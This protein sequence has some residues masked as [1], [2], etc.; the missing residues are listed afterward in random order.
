MLLPRTYT[1]CKNPDTHINPCFSAIEGNLSDRVLQIAS[2]QQERDVP[3][4]S[5]ISSGIR[6]S[7][8]QF[9]PAG[10]FSCQLPSCMVFLWD[11]TWE[12]C[13]RDNTVLCQ[14]IFLARFHGP[15]E[16]KTCADVGGKVWPCVFSWKANSVSLSVVLSLYIL[17]NKT[18]V[19][20]YTFLKNVLWAVMH[21]LMVFYKYCLLYHTLAFLFPLFL[22][23]SKPASKSNC[24]NSVLLLSTDKSCKLGN[25]LS[26]S[27]EPPAL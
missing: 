20:N 13:R 7:Q 21:A 26:V 12:L 16:Q 18:E 27:F 1:V 22:Q 15:E 14:L 11:T 3:L 6:G 17:L 23:V 9:S 8:G 5:G 10:C 4:K 2:D 24:P 19:E 25:I